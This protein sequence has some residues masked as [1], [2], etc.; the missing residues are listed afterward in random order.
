MLNIKFH[1][2][3]DIIPELM[4]AADEYMLIWNEHGNAIVA[5]LEELSN[6]NFKETFIN[7]VIFEGR[8]HSKPLSLRSNLSSNLKKAVLVHELCH[9]LIAGNKVAK[10]VGKPF[11]D[12]QTLQNHKQLDLI[13]YDALIDIFGDDIAN[14][15]VEWESELPLYK[16]AWGYALSLDRKQRRFQFQESLST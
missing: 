6:L 9:R 11:S 1:P 3:S 16:E 12:E 5:K 4:D 7:A 15:L 14:E 10:I 2:E 13:L 8:S